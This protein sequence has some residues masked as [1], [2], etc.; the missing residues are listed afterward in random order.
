MPVNRDLF[1]LG[2]NHEL[3]THGLLWGER[4]PAGRV[5]EQLLGLVLDLV[6]RIAA[7][8]GFQS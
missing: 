1:G 2:Q 4:G 6:R 7:A 5:E 8:A 3:Q